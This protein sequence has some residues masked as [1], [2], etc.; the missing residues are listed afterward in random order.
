ME[1]LKRLLIA[2]VCSALAC[3]MVYIFAFTTRQKQVLL[4]LNRK[5]KI[6]RG[7]A[8]KHP[9][10]NLLR[11][12]LLYA[13]GPNAFKMAF[14]EGR[15]TREG[16]AKLFAPTLSPDQV[17]QISLGK[18]QDE[19]DL[20]LE[21]LAPESGRGGIKCFSAAH[22]EAF[23]AARTNDEF[24]DFMAEPEA[25]REDNPIRQ[26]MAGHWIR[27][28]A[29]R[30][31]S[32]DLR[33]FLEL[34]VNARDAMLP[35]E[36][37]V[38]KFG[39][40]FFSILSFLAHEETE[41]ATI[42]IDTRQRVAGT[43]NHYKVL[44]EKAGEYAKWDDKDISFTF[45][46]YRGESGEKPGTT[47]KIKPKVGEF[48]PASLQKLCGYIY[49]V[50]PI[51]SVK[52]KVS[53]PL[54][55]GGLFE[56]GNDDTRGK[57]VVLLAPYELGVKDEGSGMSFET[58]LTSLLI[59]S[60]S[61]KGI[62]SLEDL[63][64][65]AKHEGIRLPNLTSWQGK[66]D[67]GSSYFLIT[68]NDI[69]V[70]HK[71]IDKP[72]YD[73]YGNIQ[74]IEIQMP[75]ATQLTIARDEL[76]ILPNTESFEETWVKDIIKKT[77]DDATSGAATCP[78]ETLMALY[79]GLCAWED[80]TA[81]HYI[82]GRFTHLFKQA[83]EDK[84]SGEKSKI[85]AVSAQNFKEL[86]KIFDILRDPWI[87]RNI[88]LLPLEDDLVS[89]NYSNLERIL[90]ERAEKKIVDKNG[91]EADALKQNIAQ[92]IKL[93][94]VEDRLLDGKIKSFGLRTVLFVPRSFLPIGGTREEQINK[95][96]NKFARFSEFPI[97]TP[98]IAQSTETPLIVSTITDDIVWKTPDGRELVD[99][100]MYDFYWDVFKKSGWKNIS[101]DGVF[102]FV[103][104]LSVFKNQNKILFDN[105]YCYSTSGDFTNWEKLC[106]GKD[107]KK[108]L[109]D[110][111]V[112]N[113]LCK[114]VK[115]DS[116]RGNEDSGLFFD[117]NYLSKNYSSKEI[118]RL[119]DSF[120]NLQEDSAPLPQYISV[121]HEELIQFYLFSL[122]YRF[123]NVTNPSGRVYLYM[124]GQLKQLW[125]LNSNTIGDVVDVLLPYTYKDLRL[126]PIEPTTQDM[127]I[128]FYGSTTEAERIALKKPG[129]LFGKYSSKSAMS[130]HM[131]DGWIQSGLLYE[132]NLFIPEFVGLKGLSEDQVKKEL[133][134]LRKY[135][136]KAQVYTVKFSGAIPGL[137]INKYFIDLARID[138]AC[139]LNP[140]IK[141][142]LDVVCALYDK[143]FNISNSEIPS[144]Y[145][146]GQK[147]TAISPADDVSAVDAAQFLNEFARSHEDEVDRLITFQKEDFY[148]KTNPEARAEDLKAYKFVTP[149]FLSN[150]P[151]SVL[152]RLWRAGKGVDFDVIATLIKKT[153]TSDELLFVTHLLAC[154]KNV[155]NV[156]GL[157]IDAAKKV[158]F[159]LEHYLQKRV[160]KEKLKEVALKNREKIEWAE[161]LKTF[162]SEEALSILRD[163]FK[164]Q[165]EGQSFCDRSKDYGI[166]HAMVPEHE[167]SFTLKRLMKAHSVGSGLQK[168]LEKNDLKGV[169][170]LIKKDHEKIESNKIMQCVEVGT[171]RSPLQASITETLQ[172]SLDVVKG[173]AGSRDVQKITLSI[174]LIPSKNA[175]HSSVYYSIKDEVG[176]PTLESLL[177]DLIIPDY[178]RKSPAAGNI[179][180]MGN[181]LFQ[182]Y[183]DA[184]EVL[185][186]TRTTSDPDKVFAL[187]V[188]PLRNKDNLVHDLQL[189]CVQSLA[190]NE[191]GTRIVVKFREQKN[192]LTT[193]NLLTAKDFII[194]CAGSTNL[195]TN[196]GPVK[197]VLDAEISGAK[198]INQLQ[199]ILE[200]IKI[201]MISDRDKKEHSIGLYKRE[202]SLLLESYVTTGGVPFRHLGEFLR[203]E[204][205]LPP[206][207]LSLINSGI[208][209][210]LPLGTYQPVQSRTHVK[211]SDDNK[212]R[213]R[214]FFLEVVYW[215]ELERVQDN[216]DMLDSYFEH[217]SSPVGDFVQLVLNPQD[218]A[219]WNDMYRKILQ[220][221]V[222]SSVGKKL[223]FSNY[224]PLTR[225]RK[226]FYSLITD[227]YNNFANELCVK[228][229]WYELAMENELAVH[230]KSVIDEADLQSR[231]QFWSKYS[232]MQK[233][234]FI[235]IRDTS[236]NSWKQ[237]LP[238]QSCILV[239]KVVI[240]WFDKKIKN[241][242]LEIPRV[243]N[244][245]FVDANGNPI[246]TKE[247]KN[248]EGEFDGPFQ[249]LRKNL[250]ASSQNPEYIL[251]QLKN[252]LNFYLGSYV[253]SCFEVGLLPRIFD[254]EF[255]FKEE[256]SKSGYFQSFPSK[257][258]MINFNYRS[259]ANI[260]EHFAHMV[261][262]A[263]NMQNT[264]ADLAYK[265]LFGCELGNP[266]TVTHELEHARRNEASDKGGIH[267][268]GMSASGKN[269]PFDT[270]ANSYAIKAIE[271]GCLEKWQEKMRNY[272]A[273]SGI[274]INDNL[275]SDVRKLEQIDK[276]LL[277]E[278][279]GF[280][281]D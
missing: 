38:G 90:V 114:V 71:K 44:I 199:P 137:S 181:G 172:N 39:M 69:V 253:Q 58:I 189:R 3:P 138:K 231:V 200:E 93:I 26:R 10:L 254:I 96:F 76:S 169:V 279:L 157:G 225:L 236:F 196:K 106:L 15:I 185:F 77:I 54:V 87:D 240:P 46:A 179:G 83:L 124:K 156:Q 168:L 202:G 113:D 210:D 7:E 84:L 194:N 89:N 244:I 91:L 264:K 193:M 123:G 177:A 245:R 278:K 239:D 233:K 63:R 62:T 116:C 139:E 227:A 260:L 108:V 221:E 173:F 11:I 74:D 255:Y 68:V 75:Q 251:A 21:K 122:L 208:V 109:I 144:I 248:K 53:C 42:E 213:L 127:A 277:L 117:R 105:G 142:M 274:K 265:D 33:S 126:I 66:P 110:V 203:E 32:D 268:D 16:I 130:K 120:K 92:G 151:I 60:T 216:P 9:R 48:S 14:P 271:A 25:V 107:L 170:Q 201:P 178:S 218:N 102:I 184:A 209:V 99:Y 41:G 171:E 148:E 214:A 35:A 205:L 166:Y 100:Y 150:T 55:Q 103:D 86:R 94:F 159:L 49:Y 101:C 131:E 241:L 275:I 112:A 212:K 19:M 51:P 276:K 6:K 223:F 34:V 259:V 64:A 115:I 222:I 2:V 249:Q 18:I 20:L 67:K 190:K 155:E 125:P 121:K 98:E 207:L 104:W 195:V 5:E 146:G 250:R 269:E 164:M 174:G 132:K 23:L 140:K 79:R 247:Q 4:E 28:A 52:I 258:I 215:R 70:V 111:P 31:F 206:N 211:M 56:I 228:K 8:T 165:Q 163:F 129:N 262:Q 95:L 153:R 141:S 183:K 136:Q 230:K 24:Y 143:Y 234:Q 149:S 152:A 280:E 180:D 88:V 154:G 238:K 220:G 118:E 217:F 73:Q 80:Q 188:I 160:D 78:L 59:P 133:N 219:R 119:F 226:S 82:K 176:M 13:Q 158:E 235:S 162:E 270:C 17:S 267:T 229:T 85:V 29:L 43:I 50:K 57:I 147:I 97:L 72:V 256:D 61:T 252:T 246:K 145:G 135:A 273:K 281:T 191:F 261:N 27:N 182:L 167:P 198:Q 134:F 186:I 243:E 65:Q 263:Y 81:L 36:Q 187:Q 175:G 12:L 266:G 22:L 242:E 237:G 272:L 40:G 128:A 45:H 30:I 1:L 204:N 47:I 161:R 37:A 257:K 197:L 192:L 232:E 224:T